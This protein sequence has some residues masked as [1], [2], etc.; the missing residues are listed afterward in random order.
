M[1][2]G[3]GADHS[4]PLFPISDSLSPV[5]SY[6]CALSCNF[7]HFFALG[8]IAILLFSWDCALFDKKT[9]GCGTPAASTLTPARIT[10]S[11]ARAASH[12]PAPTSSGSRV[13][14]HSAL[15]P[16]ISRF[17]AKGHSRSIHCPSQRNPVRAAISAISSARYLCEL[18]VQMVSSSSSMNRRLA[19][20]T[21]TVCRHVERRC[22][23]IRR[24]TLF[25][26]AWCRKELKSTSAPSSR[27]I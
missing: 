5:F 17:C 23:S 1:G 15:Y 21:C 3:G 11:G 9:G 6:S 10:Q 18:S 8:K 4:D 26:R 2:G 7:L 20:G 19:A 13:T 27:L 12:R 14:S 16:A 25:Q 22:I 24:S